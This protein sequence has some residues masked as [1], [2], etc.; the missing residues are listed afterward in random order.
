M[1][2]SM[3]KSMYIYVCIYMYDGVPLLYSRNWHNTSN[4]L[5][6]NWEK[7]KSHKKEKPSR[8]LP[9][10]RSTHLRS[11]LQPLDLTLLMP[12]WWQINEEFCIHSGMRK[13][14]Q[15]WVGRGWT[16]SPRARSWGCGKVRHIWLRDLCSL[17]QGH[18]FWNQE[19][20]FKHGMKRLVSQVQPE[21]LFVSLSLVFRQRSP[22]L[23]I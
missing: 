16:L 6:S 9:Q 20:M 17:R 5:Y 12:P 18:Y 3:R 19:E 11:V 13:G 21:H 10:V 22:Y 15:R 7:K 8:H 2:N 1:E 4:Q 14:H 23:H